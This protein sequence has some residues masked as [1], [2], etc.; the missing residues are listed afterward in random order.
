[1]F[2]ALF[3]ALFLQHELLSPVLTQSHKPP[4]A[5]RIVSNMG[6]KGLFFSKKSFEPNK[7]IYGSIW[8]DLNAILNP[9]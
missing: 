3:K 1:M 7:N 8:F 6:V 9:N 4:S 2:E 5:R